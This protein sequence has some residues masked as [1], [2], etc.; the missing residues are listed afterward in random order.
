MNQDR[1]KQNMSGQRV[2]YV[3]VSSVGQN[4]ERQ[5]DGL[6]LD[7]VFEDKASG[8][9]VERPELA[10]LLSHVRAG[11]VVIVHSMDRLARNVD[12]LRKIVKELTGRGVRIEFVKEGLTF[13]GE[14]SAMSNLLLTMLGAV[15]EFERSLIRER[16]LEGIAIAKKAGKYKG[17]KP[18]LDAERVAEIRE[19][20]ALG[21]PKAVLAREYG[22]SRQTLYSALAS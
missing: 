20:A 12:D 16:Q 22:V 8:K 21:I 13:T 2:G 18:S 6:K 10:S 15:A 1:K 17:R 5:L 14:D 19:K 3:R 7:R 9:S 4:T 11:D